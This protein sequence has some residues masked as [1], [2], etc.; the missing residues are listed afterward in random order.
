MRASSILGFHDSHKVQTHTQK[1]P[2]TEPDSRSP[3]R[4]VY[5]LCACVAIN[6]AR[7]GFDIGITTDAAPEI[8]DAMKL[9][10]T[11]TEL[12]VGCINIFA[13]LGTLFSSVFIDAI[14]W[15]YAFTC[16]ACSSCLVSQT[17]R[18]APV[19]RRQ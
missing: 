7:L 11:Q 13:I 18:H 17:Q 1:H 3:V 6:S 9:S 14:G 12:Y 19:P 5:L 8:Q 4:I 15:R 2:N 16:L 10:D